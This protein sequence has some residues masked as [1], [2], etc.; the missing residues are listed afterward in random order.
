MPEA[1]CCCLQTCIVVILMLV[2]EY[3][4]K[5]WFTTLTSCELKWHMYAIIM[6]CPGHFVF[7]CK[8][9]QKSMPSLLAII[10]IVLQS[11]VAICCLVTRVEEEEDEQTPYHSPIHL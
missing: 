4:Y 3:I 10:S 5:V 9:K 7:Y 11:F 1:I 6:Y 2:I 8:H